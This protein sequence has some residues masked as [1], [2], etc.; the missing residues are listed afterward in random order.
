MS[1]GRG[2][3][4]GPSVF[5]SSFANGARG[6]RGR[7]LAAGST[8]RTRKAVFFSSLSRRRFVDGS[9]AMI[10]GA[11]IKVTNNGHGAKRT[12]R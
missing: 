2:A 6:G 7:P 3:D 9:G 10:P 4:I 1:R 8:A 12:T 11:D 5:L